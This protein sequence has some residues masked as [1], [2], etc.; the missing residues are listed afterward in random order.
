[1][2]HFAP[3]GGVQRLPRRILTLTSLFPS[4]A[5]PRHG[6]FVRTRLAQLLRDYPLNCRVIAPVPWFPLD[7]PVFGSYAKFAATPRNA[8]LDDGLQVSYPRYAMVPKLGVAL[9]PDAMARAAMA[10][11]ELLSDSGWQPDLIDAHYFYP[12]GVAAAIV[13]EK[14][15][16]PLVITAR[17]TD[18]NVLARMPGPG[19]RILWAAARAASV[20]AVSNRLREALLALGVEA[21][22]VAVL[23][24][25]VDAELFRPVGTATA[26]KRIGL[27]GG[28]CALC[29]GNLVEEKGFALA[30]QALAHLGAWRLVLVGDGPQRNALERLARRLNVAERV[31]FRETMAQRELPDLYSAADVLLLTSTREGWPNVVLESLACG[32]PVVAVDVGAVGEMLTSKDVGR[33]VATRE[34][35]QLAE[36]V[37]DLMRLRPARDQVRAHALQ[38]DWATVSKVQFELFMRLCNEPNA[39]AANPVASLCMAIGARDAS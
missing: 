2:S 38:F 5:R 39:R 29:V 10:D 3:S 28:P 22:K 24:N 30:V 9:Q 19:K 11:I 16:L 25:G 6:I 21:S 32:T 1:M 4:P 13:A 26:R 34:P 27:P 37:E 14:L 33:I 18:V 7:W 36:A 31:T 8:V 12:D 20:L 35:A 17:G 15:K 23:R